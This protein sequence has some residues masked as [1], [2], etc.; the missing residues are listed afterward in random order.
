[1]RLDPS[2]VRYH[3]SQPWPFPQSLMVGFIA[4]APPAPDASGPGAAAAPPRRG[5]SLLERQGAVA[6]CGV[7][8]LPSEAERYL[9]PRLQPV[10]VG[11]WGWMLPWGGLGD[12]RHWQVEPT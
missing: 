3:S 1:M 7:G 5:L 4:Q 6:A 8:L 12:Q 11:G 2:A 9:L 10:Q